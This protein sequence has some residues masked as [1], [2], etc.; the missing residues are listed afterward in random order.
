MGTI[1]SLRTMIA[2]AMLAAAALVR[3][4][5]AAIVDALRAEGCGR[6]PAAGTVLRRDGRL[7]QVARRLPRRSLEDAVDAAAYPAAS[8]SSY[9]LKGSRDDAAIRSMLATRYCESINDPRYDEIGVFQRGDETWIVLGTRR[10]PQA[11]LDHAATLARVLELVN[12]AR[13]AP[14]TCG[15]ERFDPA[16]PLTASPFLDR[17]AAVHA[18]DLAAHGTVDHRGSD[19][20]YSGERVTRA[21][22]TWRAVGENLAAGQRDADAVV[23]AWLASPGHCASL[24]S[25]HFAEMGIAF[26]LAPRSNPAIYWAQV[27]AAPL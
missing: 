13:A 24:M 19:G 15:A 21:G 18:Q 22:Y 26:A 5:P 2:F 16:P 14:R 11:P 20:T 3:A 17:A 6:A 25:P 7:E 27:F 10:A 4:D 8:V 23:A 1:R 12:A 9:H